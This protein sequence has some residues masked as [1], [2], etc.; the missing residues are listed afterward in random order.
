MRDALAAAQGEVSERD[1][2]LADATVRV[3]RAETALA[4]ASRARRDAGRD[5][6]DVAELRRLRD[7]L[8][9]AQ[10]S[11]AER[12]TELTQAHAAVD[13]ARQGLDAAIEQAV[14]E[15]EEDWKALDT[16]RIWA[17][18][19]QWRKEAQSAQ[20]RA[21]VTKLGLTRRRWPSL[22]YLWRAGFA[23]VAIGLV[24]ALYPWSSRRSRNILGPDL[25]TIASKITDP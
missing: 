2:E 1:A 8:A 12:D 7:A 25:G 3:E 11:L 18:R 19:I 24:L 20:A 15:A 10:A 4:E 16:K 13:Q 14:K 23:M 22:R 6:E 9:T 17:A 5:P 21:A